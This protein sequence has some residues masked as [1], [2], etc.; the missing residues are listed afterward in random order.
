M[1]PCA[2]E[3]GV[4]GMGDARCGVCIVP[5][6]VVGEVVGARV[7]GGL[8]RVVAVLGEAVLVHLEHVV[9]VHEVLVQQLPVGVPHVDLAMHR[10]VA[11]HPVP[12]DDFGEA[13]QPRT[14]SGCVGV[15]VDEEEALPLLQPKRGEVMV[16]RIERVAG[17]VGRAVH[18]RRADQLAIE[19]IDPRVVRARDSC[20]VAAAVEQW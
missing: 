15:L 20:F 5:D 3:G 19:A 16:R 8:Q 17:C 9:G 11:G 12:T 13:G 4:G 1:A 2:L 18:V 7:H 6:E 10:H 14:E